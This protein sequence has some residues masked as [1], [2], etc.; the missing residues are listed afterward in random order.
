MEI[1]ILSPVLRKLYENEAQCE[2]QMDLLMLPVRI[3]TD[4]PS[5]LGMHVFSLRDGASK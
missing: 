2:G 3:K 4:L 5:V 1:K